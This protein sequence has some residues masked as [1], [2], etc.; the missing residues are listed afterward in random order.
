MCH[1]DDIVLGTRFTKDK[2]TG[3]STRKYW[4]TV[5]GFL[6]ESFSQLTHAQRSSRTGPP[7]YIGLNRVPSSYAILC[8]LAGRYVYSAELV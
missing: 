7:V 3:A 4:K 2:C 5:A 6:D 1:Y 8:S